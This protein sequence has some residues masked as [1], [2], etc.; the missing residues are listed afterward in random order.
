MVAIGG[1]GQ[2]SSPTLSPKNFDNY[3]NSFAMIRLFLQYII[4][5]ADT[6]NPFMIYKYKT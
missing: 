5:S 2:I 4:I 1:G 6:I 3:F